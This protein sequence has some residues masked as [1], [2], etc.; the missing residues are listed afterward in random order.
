MQD[1][2][3]L[4]INF[5]TL[6]DFTFSSRVR[7]SRRRCGGKLWHEGYLYKQEGKWLRKQYPK[8]YFRLKGHMLT[9][10][11]RAG[12]S[13][14]DA[15]GVVSILNCYNIKEHPGTNFTRDKKWRGLELV[16]ADHD[17]ASALLRIKE[18]AKQLKNQVRKRAT[19]R[20]S[21][22]P[23]NARSVVLF[24]QTDQE[25]REWRKKLTDQFHTTHAT[26][27]NDK[28]A[29]QQATAV[30]S[31]IEGWMQ[32][33][34]LVN[35]LPS[36]T[37]SRLYIRL[38]DTRM[39]AFSRPSAMQPR[40]TFR[41]TQDFY[42]GDSR[43][44]QNAFIVSDFAETYN[45]VTETA[46][47]KMFWMQTIAKLLRTL[48]GGSW[49]AETLAGSGGDA[50]AQKQKHEA[51]PPPP[52]KHNP[53]PPNKAPAPS[54][55]RSP[56]GPQKKAPAPEAPVPKWRKNKQLVKGAQTPRRRLLFRH[57]RVKRALEIYWKVRFRQ[58]E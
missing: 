10:W 5:F 3:A 25:F 48:A 44:R 18:K 7:T 40:Y 56:D 4:S 43:Q 45:F 34:D 42:V 55:R 26:T 36:D 1:S 54:A 46:P 51:P 28:Y 37:W 21:S 50:K 33:R 24:S 11:D 39:E 19:S 15:K 53:S 8:Y 38:F 27:Q 9:Y 6:Y 30:K 17:K 52:P 47:E 49:A 41:L 22:S 31:V 57:C 35:G 12:Q 23:A 58:K 2:C 14:A 16:G 13:D 20:A 32:M 29:P